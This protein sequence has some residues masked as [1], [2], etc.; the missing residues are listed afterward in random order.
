MKTQAN[1]EIPLKEII[2][3]LESDLI[4]VKGNISN[5]RIKYLKPIEE[6]DEYSLDWVSRLKN[7]KQ[8]LEESSIAKAIIVDSNVTYT[9]VIKNADK[10]LIYVNNPKAIISKI[11]HHFF[12]K[13]IKPGIHPSACIDEEAEIGK[14]VFIG[15]FCTIGKCVIGNNTIIHSNVSIYDN[16]SIGNNCLIHS[17]AVI[18]T[19]GLGCERSEN[20]TLIKFPHLGGVIIGNDIEIGANC[21]IAKGAL[22]NTIIGDGSKIN[23]GCYIA[24][25]SVLGKNIWISAQ[26]RIAGS[27]KIED[28]VTIF[29]GAIVR[30]QKKIGKDAIIGMGAVV[31][32]DVPAGETWI[33]N[34]AKKME[35]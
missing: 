27:V 11:G 12:T 13:K 22:S 6:V 32:K 34:P 31:T 29:I 2:D 30:E 17:G 25:N 20:G 18:G 9:D 23:V 3:F 19:D 21:Q 10:V 5:K 14:D 24:H 16:V 7:N 8:E 26:A 33:G 28:N 35:K 1:K 4:D 15:P